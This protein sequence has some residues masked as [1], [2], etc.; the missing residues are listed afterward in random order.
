M[1]I[2]KIK[3]EKQKKRLLTEDRG[4]ETKD[5]RLKRGGR[6]RNKAERRR[7]CKDRKTEERKLTTED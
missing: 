1:K 7:P 4:L 2:K 5:S 6:G 3:T